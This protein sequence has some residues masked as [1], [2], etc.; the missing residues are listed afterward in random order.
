MEAPIA[1]GEDEMVEWA[2]RIEEGGDRSLVPD[3]HGL[4][5]GARAERSQR[6]LGI[7]EEVGMVGQQAPQGRHRLRMVRIGAGHCHGGDGSLRRIAGTSQR[8]A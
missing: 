2:C 5:P 4:T 1:R 6:V 3:I 8:G 7:R